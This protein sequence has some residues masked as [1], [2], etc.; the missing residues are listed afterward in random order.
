MTKPQENKYT[1]TAIILHWL[2]GFAILGMF[3]LG[4]FMADLPKDAPKAML[5]DLFDLGVY[6][7]P[8]SEAQSPRMFYFN[9][10]KSIGVTLLA[11]IALRVLWRITHRPPALLVSLTAF[12]RKLSHATHHLLYVLMVAVPVAGF[13]TSLYGK[14]GVL[15]F[16]IPLVAGLENEA[17]HKLLEEVHEI[18]GIVLLVV[19]LLHVAG[20]LKHKFIDK[21][22]T[23][24]RMSLR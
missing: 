6:N 12:E 21:D 23:L 15:W 5:F 22:E 18:T 3:G 10:H 11:L 24:K 17:L 1:K 13:L 16:G 9:L 8:L 20:A 14:Y 7:W 2:I 19:V 4:W